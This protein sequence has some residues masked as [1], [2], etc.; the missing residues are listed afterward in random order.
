MQL[1]V[2]IG[3]IPL[4]LE[5]K[6]FVTQSLLGILQFYCFLCCPVGCTDIGLSCLGKLGIHNLCH[7]LHEV[8]RFLGF[9]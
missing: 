2:C 4:F 1:H 3:I 7:S 9:L 8:A 6:D 5:G